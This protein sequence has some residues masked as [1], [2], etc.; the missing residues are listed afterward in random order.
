MPFIYQSQWSSYNKLCTH[1]DIYMITSELE[2][3][4]TL[5]LLVF[6]TPIFTTITFF[7]C[8]IWSH[9]YYCLFT[10][11]LPGNVFRRMGWPLIN[12]IC[13]DTKYTLVEKECCTWKSVAAMWREIKT[14][15]HC[16][17][18]SSTSPWRDHFPRQEN[19]TE[20]GFCS[21]T[22]GWCITNI[23]Q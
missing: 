11:Y 13:M 5:S 16:L 9:L 14:Y 22:S 2:S 18:S 21:E 20:F 7:W 8:T 19:N 4:I 12:T 15:L 3:L 23:Y 1:I 6:F 17:I 10:C